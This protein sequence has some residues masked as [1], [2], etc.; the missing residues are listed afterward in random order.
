LEQFEPHGPGNMKPVFMATN[1]FATDMRVLKDAHLKITMLQPDRDVALEGIGFNLA[2]KQ[3]DVASGLPF[4]V[5]FTLESNVW[6]DRE[7]LQLN[8]KD[9]RPTV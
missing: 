6:K 4:D 3:D 1:V 5:V 9:V 8:I 7:T 2:E